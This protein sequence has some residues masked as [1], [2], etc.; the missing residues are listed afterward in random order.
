[1]SSTVALI[2]YQ[3]DFPLVINNI[4]SISQR[5]G[6]ITLQSLKPPHGSIVL[7]VKTSKVEKESLAITRYIN[8]RLTLTLTLTLYSAL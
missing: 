3:Y 5:F 8:L 1:M 2:E 6:N 4:S 7:K